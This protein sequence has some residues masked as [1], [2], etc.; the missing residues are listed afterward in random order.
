MKNLSFFFC[1]SYNYSVMD[2]KIIIKEASVEKVKNANS[3]LTMLI[4][5]ERK[6]DENL[7]DNVVINEFYEHKKENS[8][9]YFA[10][11]NEDIIGYIYG[12]I[13]KDDLAVSIVAQLDALFIKKEYRGKKVAQKL[14]EEFKIWCNLQ[15]AKYIEVV[16]YCDNME[17]I[18]TYLK[19]GFMPQKI[20]FIYGTKP[21][22]YQKLVRDKIPL[23]IKN[24]NEKAITKIL[25]DMEY[26]L[27]LE[28]K[29]Y[30]EYIEVLNASGEERLEEL[31]DMLEVMKALANLN[32]NTLDDIINM[33]EKKNQKRGAFK[34]KIYLEGVNNE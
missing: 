20:R 7:M 23:K 22:Y 16:A 8:I 32:G 17:A 3:F 26:K 9:I 21:K 19:Q 14:I 27:E 4:N 1:I 10:Y 11:D 28:K 25:D 12:F 15:G 5:S 2:M 29:L 34:E 33:A 13:K 24:N 31:A 30:E 18:K 6:Y